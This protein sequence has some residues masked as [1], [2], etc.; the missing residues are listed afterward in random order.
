MRFDRSVGLSSMGPSESKICSNVVHG[1][2]PSAMFHKMLSVLR[3][4]CTQRAIF[5]LENT[6]TAGLMAT[7][8]ALKPILSV[9]SCDR[10][11][12]T[13]N[14]ASAMALVRIACSYG[15]GSGSFGPFQICQ[16]RCALFLSSGIKGSGR[17]TQ[18][19]R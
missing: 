6:R 4:V 5:C 3:T 18:R 13:F 1:M 8:R 12:P 11:W 7:S 14:K 16:A 19:Q 9:A 17:C 2:I 10:E 15:L